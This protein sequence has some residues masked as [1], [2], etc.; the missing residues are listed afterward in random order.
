MKK[1]EK[2]RDII[3][4]LLESDKFNNFRKEDIKRVIS[5]K[6]KALDERTVDHW[7]DLFWNLHYFI[8]PKPSFYAL[9][10]PKIQ[11]LEVKLPEEVDPKQR[12]LM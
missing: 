3:E 1:E 7:F 5:T 8:Q 4:A 9:N 11:E 2:I 12:R 10:I 6:L